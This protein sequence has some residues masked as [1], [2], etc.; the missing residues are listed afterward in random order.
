MSYRY[1]YIYIYTHTQQRAEA[2]GERE[3]GL[4]TQLREALE[5]SEENT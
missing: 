1:I 4:V 2:L 3:R 5:N